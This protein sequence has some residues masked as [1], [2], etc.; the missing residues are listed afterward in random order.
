M[1]PDR[2]AAVDKER[3]QEVRSRSSPVEE[4]QRLAHRHEGARGVNLATGLMH[5]VV[6][7]ASSV[8]NVTQTHAQLHGWRKGRVGWSGYQGVGKRPENASK[9]ID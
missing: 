5:W 3:R 2:G 8:A 9:E 7:T 1:P 6:D 4:R